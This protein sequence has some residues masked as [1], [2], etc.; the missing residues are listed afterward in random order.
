MGPTEIRPAT[1]FTTSSVE[2]RK[3]SVPEKGNG[4]FAVKKILSGDIIAVWGGE[5]I[6]EEQ[7]QTLDPYWTR[8]AVQVEEDYYIVSSREGA[9]DY[10]NHNCDANAGLR[11]PI[12]LVALRDIEPGEE[13]CYDY[14]MTDSA[15]YDKFKC[16]CGSPKCRGIVY[17][18]DWKLPELWE[19]YGDH[20]SPYILRKIEKYQ[21]ELPRKVRCG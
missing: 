12:T 5:I 16:Y 6:N 1:C 11:G 2:P 17:G 19:Q 14:A 10:V 15:A 18:S 8:Y 21:R 9:A 4:L 7:I 3:C 13:V 20:F